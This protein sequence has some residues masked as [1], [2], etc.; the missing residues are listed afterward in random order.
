[1]ECLG[2]GGAGGEVGCEG[3]VVVEG[4]AGGLEGEGVE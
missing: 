3:V 2:I 1:M 4:E